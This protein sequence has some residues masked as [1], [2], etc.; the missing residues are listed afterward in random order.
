[1]ARGVPDDGLILG[2]NVHGASAAFSDNWPNRASFWFPAN[3]HPSDKATVSFTVHAPAGRRVVANGVQVGEPT[4]A[5]SS[6]VAGL[7]SLM[8][9]TWVNRVPIPTYLMVVGAAPLEVIDEGLAACGA[10]PASSRSDGCIEVTAWA[11]PQDTAYARTAFARVPQMVDLYVDL[12]G[13]YPFEKLANV[14]SS[15][16]FRGMEN[17]SVIFYDE[18]RIAAREDFEATV[19]HEVV[20]QWF[21]NS[22]TPADWPHLWLSEGFASYF[23]ALFWAQTQDDA[24]FRERIDEMRVRYLASATTDQPIVDYEVTNLLDLLNDNSY[25]KG[26]LVLHMLRGVVG[27]RA[28]FAAIR[29]FYQE[30]EGGHAQTADFQRV[31]EDVSGQSLGWFFDQWLLR[32]GHPVLRVEWTWRADTSQAQITLTQVQSDL[33]PTFRLPIDFE[34]VLEGGIHRVSDWV[35]AR[36]WRRDIALP[37]QPTELRLDPD[38]WLILEQTATP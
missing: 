2:Q 15:T 28:F 16:R 19:A 33:W 22:V 7:D 27:E 9:W 14:Q 12:F 32:P 11:F 23:G 26:A 8:T 29:R 17:A 36:V 20:H 18:D 31:M 6:R 10:A 34:F 35:D 5:D 13:P 30:H 1:M 21:G 3:D 38:G 24:A 4:P 25:Q 37:G